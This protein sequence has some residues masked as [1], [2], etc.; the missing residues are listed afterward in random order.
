VCTLL[1]AVIWVV[2]LAEPGGAVEVLRTRTAG[3]ATSHDAVS[4]VERARQLRLWR[5]K[6]EA[7]ER[8]NSLL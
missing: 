1:R 7:K 4:W 6:E 5:Q 2:A 3:A 8:E